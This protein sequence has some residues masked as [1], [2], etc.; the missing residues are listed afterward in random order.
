MMTWDR[1]KADKTYCPLPWIHLATNAT[2]TLRVC[3]N[4]LPLSNKLLHDNDELLKIHHLQDVSNLDRNKTLMELRRQ[5][6]NGERPETCTRCFHEEDN[7][8]VSSRMV[9]R[10]VFDGFDYALDN[11]K[12]DGKAPHNF[13]YLDLR[14]GNLCNLRCRMCNPYTSS[15]LVDES[16]ELGVISKEDADFLRDMEWPSSERLW[17]LLERNLHSIELIYLTGGE[18]TLILEQFRLLQACIDGGYASQI[19]LKYNTNMTNIP[20]KFYDYWKHFLEV[21]INCS[22][23]GLNDVCRYVRNPSNWKAIHKNLQTMEQYAIENDNIKSEIHTTVQVANVTRLIEVFDYFRPY[24]KIANFPFLNL[25]NQPNYYNV[26]ILPQDIK[27]EISKE[28]MDWY[29]EHKDDYKGT[30]SDVPNK[31]HKI[32][33]LVS[34]MNSADWGHL[35]PQFKKYTQWFDKKRGEDFVSVAPRL[36]EWYES[37]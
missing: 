7:G 16:E 36:K 32:P 21:K 8:I 9:Y 24:E 10:E 30:R 1:E 4:S 13:R 25:L 35:A 34:Y 33:G 37:I 27:D 3:C 14:L 26:K 6:M 22:V 12:D 29:D 11:T 15:Q 2:G 5:M 17:K 19:K 31:V 23:D 28:L 18:P 20:H